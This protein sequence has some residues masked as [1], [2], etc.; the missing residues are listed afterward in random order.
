MRGEIRNHAG[1]WQGTIRARLGQFHH[2]RACTSHI[3]PYYPARMKLALAFFV[4]FLMAAVLAT[5]CV[6]AVNGKFWL[7]GLG[8]ASFVVLVAKFGC[9]THD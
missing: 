1:N 3:A 9:L 7:L 5:G 4:W 8:V 6:M 2:L